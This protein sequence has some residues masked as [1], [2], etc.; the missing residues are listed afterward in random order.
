MD[1]PLGH[2]GTDAA[3]ERWLVNLPVPVTDRWTVQVSLAMSG[4]FLATVA[5]LPA[6]FHLRI[7]GGARDADGTELL[8]WPVQGVTQAQ[9]DAG[10]PGIGQHHIAI[11]HVA[12]VPPMLLKLTGESSI[13]GE[14]IELRGGILQVR[15]EVAMSAGKSPPPG[16]DIWFDLENQNGEPNSA[17]T[18]AGDWLLTAGE[19]AVIQSLTRRY[20]TSPDEYKVKPGYKCAGLREAVRRRLR[21]SDISDL[22]NRMRVATAAE[23]RVTSN[24]QITVFSLPGEENGLGFRV[25]I[26]FSD[27]LKTRTFSGKVLA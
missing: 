15:K 1:G 17:V 26:Q 10:Y 3:D 9:I 18:V 14:R 11:T 21:Q 23:P 7:S 12:V 13:V 20:L 8:S 25:S 24:T 16:E 22:T 19:E 4:V 2:F 27:S 6:T 5:D